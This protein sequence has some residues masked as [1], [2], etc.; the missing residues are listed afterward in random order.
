M[1]S[2]ASDLMDV[3]LE[4][5]KA[6]EELLLTLAEEQRHIVALDIERLEENRL[7]KENAITSL[8]R[9]QVKCAEMIRIAGENLGKKEIRTLSALMA[10]AGVSVQKELRPLQQRLLGL[11]GLLGRQLEVNR[12]IIESSLGMVKNSM[13]LFGRLLGG[14]AETYSAQG[15]ISMGRTRGAIFRRDI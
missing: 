7:R 1:A 4:Q 9:V 10:A 3:M 13:E 8:G 6:M 11:A 14:G 15:R 12:K 2:G 5:E